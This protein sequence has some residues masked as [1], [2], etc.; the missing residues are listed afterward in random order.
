MR[1]MAW[2]P[3]LTV[4]SLP[5]GDSLDSSFSSAESSSDPAVEA[6]DQLGQSYADE[7]SFLQ[8]SFVQTP[9]TPSTGAYDAL[10]S[11]DGG[12]STDP[13][14]QLEQTVGGLLGGDDTSG[15]SADEQLLDSALP[16]T[17]LDLYA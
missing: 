2:I 7:V 3:P 8:S 16:A 4:A 6:L 15:L 12:A 9:V 11:L 13:A 1:K 10:G 17:P 14:T 5:G